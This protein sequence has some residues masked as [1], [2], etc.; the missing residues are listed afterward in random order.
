M[1]E[2]K[3]PASNS[4]I[5][6]DELDAR[7]AIHKR[8]IAEAR[9]A[10]RVSLLQTLADAGI[11]HVIVSFDGYS[12]S[13]QIE[14]V[15]AKR[16]DS[17]VEFPAIEIDWLPVDWKADEHQRQPITLSD[18]VE[19]IVYDCLEVKHPGWEIDD[20]AF[21]EVTFDVAERRITL[22]YNERFTGSEYFQH[23]F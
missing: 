5:N 3:T 23:V 2:P 10:N 4:P 20:G 6:W 21:G 12:D 17:V 15:E 19:A 1:N 14:N 16:G 18:A 13:G 9:P 22:D 7:S 8:L 11:T